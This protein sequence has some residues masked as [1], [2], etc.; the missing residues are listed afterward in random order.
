MLARAYR[1]PVVGYFLSVLRVAALN[2]RSVIMLPLG[3]L[4]YRHTQ[5]TP[6]IAYQSLIWL[7]CVS[8]GRFNDLLSRLIAWRRPKIAIPSPIGVL[9]DVGGNR[10]SELADQLRRDGYIVF[11][12][13]LGLDACDRLMK[14]ALSTP[15]KVRRMDNEPAIVTPLSV[16]FDPS[17]PLAVR[18][19][20]S[21]SVL[22]D[23]PDV[24]HLLADASIL[25]VVQEYLGCAPLSDVLS[26]WWHTGFHAQPDSEA[27]QFFH[28]DMDRVK[29]LK[30]FVYITDVG[31]ENGPHSFVRGSHRSG[32]IPNEFLRRGYVRLLDD[33][34]ASTY[35]AE[36]VL[37]FSAPRGSIIIEDT[38][39]LHKGANV[40]GAPRLILQLQFSN[41]LF[42][43]NYP[44]A[45]VSKVVDP[46][47]KAMLA[48]VPD[49]YRQYTGTHVT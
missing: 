31:P 5:R 22:L 46:A 37:Q 35:P 33:E 44:P 15:A 36:D 23:D 1:I 26:M 41:S 45:K 2:L 21:P 24:Q 13:A 27:A 42:G 14:L 25:Q 29:W 8:R 48:R 28:F 49:V 34:V 4:S 32:A 10:A 38:R 18:Y 7:F 19:D 30:I 40:T 3:F 12:T 39:G 16:L 9:G 20:Y 47:F 43:T 6:E 11:P 17:K